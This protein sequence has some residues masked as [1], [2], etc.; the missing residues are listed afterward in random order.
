MGKALHMCYLMPAAMDMQVGMNGGINPS[1]STMQAMMSSLVTLTKM[2][3]ESYILAAVWDEKKTA[4]CVSP[5]DDSQCI[6]S[7]C[8]SQTFLTR[9]LR[10]WLGVT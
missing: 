2:M 8:G 6:C 1:Y 3:T 10:D 4:E 5:V 7:K 9:I